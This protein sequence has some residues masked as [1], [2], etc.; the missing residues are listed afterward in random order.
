MRFGVLGPLSVAKADGTPVPVP[1]VE[2]RA[3]LAL[4]LLHEGRLVPVDRLIGDLWPGS[5]PAHPANALQIRVA[6]LRRALEAA[7]PGARAL[8]EH[9]SAGY[10]LRVPAES[11]DSVRFQMLLHRAR[12]SVDP[13]TRRQVLTEALTLWRGPALAGFEDRAFTQPVAERLTQ[14]RLAA[15]EDLAETRLDLGEHH[16]VAAELT[17][18]VRRHPGRER[19][20]AAQMRALHRSGRQAEALAAYDEF[21]R[22]MAVDLGL[23]PSPELA[24]LH[25]AVLVRDPALETPPGQCPT[26]LP[27]PVTELIGREA[28]V[29]DVLVS[30]ESRR[31]VTLTGPGGVGKTRLGVAVAA[32]L[33][34]SY[35]DGV[36][37]VELTGLDGAHA[38]DAVA[39]AVMAVLGI[40]ENTM[41]GPVPAGEPMGHVDRLTAFLRGKR[42]LLLLDNCEHVAG[43]VAELVLALLHAAPG[44]RVL[45]TGRERLGMAGEVLYAVPPLDVPAPGAE[46]EA[47]RES[48]AARLFCARAADADPGFALEASNARVVTDLVRGL[49]GLPLA[50]ELA[51]AKV[52]ALGVHELAA[53]LDDRFQLLAAGSRGA[54]ARHRTLQAVLDWSWELLSDNERVV[55][56]RLAVMDGGTLAAIESICADGDATA[57]GVAGTLAQLVDRS[58][59]MVTGD[60]RYRLLQT[61]A[62]YARARLDEAEESD[63]VRARH[64]QYHVSMAEALLPGLFGPDQQSCLQQL[65]TEHG[66][67]HCALDHAIAQGSAELALRLVDALSWSLL[68]RGRV[69]QAARWADRALAVAGPA[70]QALRARVHSWQ[71]GIA[72]LLDVEHDPAAAA[73]TALTHFSG[74]DDPD[75]LAMARWFLAYVLLHAGDL[76]TSE[77]LAMRAA[78]G[79]HTLGHPWGQAV[80]ASLRANHA[81]ARGDLTTSQAACDNALALFRSLGDRGGE[82][83]TVYPRAALAEIRGD[84]DTA[85]RL[86]RDGLRLAEDLGMWAEAA[87]R[88]SGLGRIAMLRDDYGTARELHERAR[89]LAAE[90]GFKAG[91]VYAVIGLGQTARHS[92]D[93]AAASD[94]LHEAAAWYR[95]TVSAPGY[96]AVLSELG[97]I[98]ERKGDPAEAAAYHRRALASARRLGN[99]LAQATALEGIAGAHLLAGRQSQAAH[100]LGAAHALRESSGVT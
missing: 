85:E 27:T 100:L 31:L 41:L 19:L 74:A 15:L 80:V 67:L 51:A 92:G 60:R 49:D 23:D 8:V 56:R 38:A 5:L 71:A 88:L 72:I 43:Q 86:H 55:L 53:R 21:R 84:H 3:L 32:A 54:P 93:L 33:A 24:A 59:V 52:R 28:A 26:N 70:P 95:R 61:I 4:L 46:V 29:A 14:Q 63:A 13:W 75:G 64:S 83:L 9:R 7:E 47:I 37:L 91:E 34:P 20:V 45:A 1:G 81:L 79:F 44:L 16:A 82:L 76:D 89:R 98:A 58:M 39:E 30:L 78:A 42:L 62:A 65:D 50:L 22:R 36:W 35:P 17:E 68:L 2:V 25:Q 90:H 48:S 77:E 6:R 11:I 99:P 97:F 87:D 57:R 69:R 94:H 73:R 66:N 40:R 18:W 10:R 12:T 96:A